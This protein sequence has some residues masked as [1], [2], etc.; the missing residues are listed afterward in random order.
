M[1]QFTDK[2]AKISL[3]TIGHEQH[4]VL[5]INKNDSEADKPRKTMPNPNSKRQLNF[6][7]LVQVL[8]A[9]IYR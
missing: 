9:V 8:L 6:D 2:S 7:L 4:P 5:N 3:D 1:C